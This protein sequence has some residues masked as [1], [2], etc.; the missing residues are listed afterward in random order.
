LDHSD[1]LQTIAEIGATFAGFSALV[2]AFSQKGGGG[3]P[4]DLTRLHVAVGGALMVV[5]GGI[6][7]FVVS[8]Y[9]LADAVEWRVSAALLLVLNYLYIL[10]YLPWVRRLRRNVERPF[11]VSPVF[12]A[13]EVGFQLPLIALILGFSEER[14]A[15]LYLT[16]LVALLCQGAAT[17]LALV[18]SIVSEV[19]SE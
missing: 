14:G 16:A 17:F 5:F 11:E 3:R 1:V 4:V 7:P 18:T 8:A 12:W 9:S 2:T 6:A 10:V 15:A 19:A 13:L